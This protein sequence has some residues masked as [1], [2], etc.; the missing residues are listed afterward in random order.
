LHAR[1]HGLW[2]HLVTGIDTNCK[3]EAYYK[4]SLSRNLSSEFPPVLFVHGQKD[5]DVPFEMVKRASQV[6]PD[7]ILISSERAGHGFQNASP[8]EMLSMHEEVLTFL[9]EKLKSDKS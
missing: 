2:G 1:Q 7:C 3:K 6:I 8:E 5:K 4:Y 9:I